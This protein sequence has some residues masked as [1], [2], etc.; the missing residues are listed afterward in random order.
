MALYLEELYFN[1]LSREQLKKSFDI[2]RNLLTL[3]RDA[4]ARGF[5]PG[6]TLKAGPWWS[7]EEAKAVFVLD[8]E[9]PKN[10][11]TR[12]CSYI[13]QGV[14]AKRRL[15]PIVDWDTVQKTDREV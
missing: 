8:I 6:L 12:F 1:V 11:F 4:L 14:I 9:D 5:S 13:S 10:T 3:L 7:A 15:S 2:I